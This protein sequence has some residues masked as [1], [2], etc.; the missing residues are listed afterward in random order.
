MK[1]LRLAFI[2]AAWLLLSAPSMAQ[3]ANGGFETGALPPWSCTGD[4]CQ[5]DSDA[6]RTGTYDFQGFSNAVDGV[7]S[8]VIATVPG[9]KYTIS[10]WVRTSGDP[11][12]VVRLGLGS[13][14]PVD[15][16]TLTT[17]YAL[18]TATFTAQ[19]SGDAVHLYFKTVGGSGVVYIDDVSVTGSAAVVPTLGEWALLALA[20]MLLVS[21]WAMARNRVPRA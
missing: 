13:S 12:N 19:T 11:I 5:V 4:L 7:L 3:I 10:A 1:P 2:A 16:A 18:C 9:A 17:T 8:Q 21:G 15:C 14:A 6:P 20:G